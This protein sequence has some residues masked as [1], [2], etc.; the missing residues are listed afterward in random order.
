MTSVF[1]PC[2]M[3]VQFF[4]DEGNTRSC[5]TTVSILF[6]MGRSFLLHSAAR[7]YSRENGATVVFALLSWISVSDRDVD[8]WHGD[9]LVGDDLLWRS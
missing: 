8:E 2:I 5:L 4:H 3:V 6:E 1:V 7:K 9:K